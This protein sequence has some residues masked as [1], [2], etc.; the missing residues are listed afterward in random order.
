MEEKRRQ[1][2]CSKGH[3]MAL[4]VLML[5]CMISGSIIY[6]SSGQNL[7]A[8]AVRTQ[9]AEITV[10]EPSINDWTE[11]AQNNTKFI[12][13]IWTD[14]TVFKDDVTLP[15]NP[16]KVD[17]GESDFLIALSAISSTSNIRTLSG[18]V[19]LDIVMVLDTSGSM[20]DEMGYE[21]AETYDDGYRWQERYVLV[22][23][24]YVRIERRGII[25]WTWQLN[26][27]NIEVKHSASDSGYQMYERVNI[28]KMDSLK[29]AVNNFIDA[30]ADI[31]DGISES[32]E[33][34]RI[35]IVNY[36]SDSSIR[37]HFAE[38]TKDNSN[39][40]K[41]VV[42]ELN[43]NGA[44]AADYGMA[45]AAEEIENSRQ[46]AKTVVIFFT[47]G[48]PNHQNGFD[49]SVA[50]SAIGTAKVLKDGGTV[51]YSVGIFEN[52]DPEGS[53][54]ANRYMNGISNNYPKAESYTN[55]GNRVSEDANYYK[56]AS[57][58]DGLN[59]IFNEILEESVSNAGYPTHIERP[60]GEPVD[61]SKSGYVTFTDK[62]GA[63]MQ[64]DSFKS[65]VFADERFDLPADGKTTSGDTDTYVFEGT[66]GNTLY[67]NGNLSS[68][69]ITVKHGKNLNDG[70]LV[71]VSVPAAMIP[72]RDFDVDSENPYSVTTTVNDTWPIRIFYG[73][74]LKEGIVKALENPD[75]ALA[76]YISENSKDGKVSFYSNDFTKENELGNTTSE[77]TPAL[78]NSFYYFT[79]DSYLF[80]DEDCTVPITGNIQGQ[81]GYYYQRTYY[82]K[83]SSEPK[84]YAIDITGSGLNQLLEAARRDTSK[85]GQYYIP[86][87]TP[88]LTTVSDTYKAKA[89]NP[90]GTAGVVISPV[91][92][93]LTVSGAEDIVV[94]LGNNGCID[95]DLPGTLKISK[96][97][98]TADGFDGKQ[99]ENTE[100]EF[101]ID[102]GEATGTYDTEIVSKDGTKTS[103]TI[104]NGDTF[105]LKTGE[106]IYIYGVEAGVNYI[107]TEES[108][109]GFTAKSE[110]NSGTVISG[111]EKDIKFTNTYK[112]EI[113]ASVDTSEFFKGYK[114]LTGRDW[115]A[116][117]SFRFILD[118]GTAPEAEKPDVTLTSEEDGNYKENSRVEFDFGKVIFT[119]PGVYKYDIFEVEPTQTLPGMSYSSARYQV[120]VTVEDNGDGTMSAVSEMK[121]VRN[122]EGEQTEQTVS[123]AAFTNKY[124]AKSVMYGPIGYKE[125][126]DLSGGGMPLENCNFKFRVTPLTEGAPVPNGV[127][128]SEKSFTV[129]QGEHQINYGNAEFT[130]QHD[131]PYY[132]YLLEEV[133][134][135]G[136][137]ETNNYVLNGMR[138][139]PAKYIARFE[140][141]VVQEPGQ[142][143]QIKVTV[144]YWHTIDGKTPLRLIDDRAIHFYNSYDPEDAVL[145]GNTAL[146]GEKTIIGRDMKDEEMFTFN[147]KTDDKTTAQ[148]V[149]DGKIVI[150]GWD[151]TEEK[152][153][154]YVS[155]AKN[156]VAAGFNFGDA[157][158]TEV[159]TYKF[160]ITEESGNAGGVSYD[161]HETKV[162]VTVTDEKGVLKAS[163]NY[164][165][166][167]DRHDDKAVFENKYKASLDYGQ[168]GGIIVT[169][170][171][172]GRAMNSGEFVFTMTSDDNE[173]SQSDAIFT[174]PSGRDGDAVIMKKLQ[175]LKFTEADVGKTFTY[176]LDE[177]DA[178][179]AKG[180][181]YD[182]SKYK[183][184]I[185]VIDSE[186]DGKLSAETV[187]TKI[188]DSQGK[189]VNETVGRYDSAQ[190]EI[191]QIAF[192][193]SYHAE[194]FDFET[195][196]LFTK[197]LRGRNW[198]DSDEFK[199][200]IEAVTENAPMPDNKEVKISKP[201]KGESVKFGFGKITY[202]SAGVYEYRITEEA[203]NIPGITYSSNEAVLRVTVSDNGDGTFSAVPGIISGTFE[204]VYRSSIDYGAAG[205]LEI[206]KTLTGRSMEKDLFEFTV[207]G[208]DKE[209]R[210]KLKIDENGLKFTNENAA[211]GETVTVL[212]LGEYFDFGMSDIGKTYTYE[213][214][215]TDKGAAGYVYDKT[216]RTVEISIADNLDGNMRVV[217]KINGGKDTAEYTY[218]TGEAAS[219]KASVNF[220]NKYQAETTAETAASL[221]ADKK[222][223]GRPLNDGE[224][225]FEVV[226]K[227][228]TP[229]AVMT[230][231]NDA[232]GTINFNKKFEYTTDTLEKAVKDG[233]AV[234]SES[235]KGYQWT[236]GY[237][238][239]EDTT[240]FEDKGITAANTAYDFTVIVTDNGDGTLT[241]KV[242]YPEGESFKFANVYSTGE[243][244]TINLSGSKTLKAEDGLLPDDI[245]GKFTFTLTGKDNAPMPALNKTQN[246]KDG[247]I[248]FGNVTFSLD[249]LKGVKTAEDGSRTK[250]F[251]Y[252]VSES[253]T[254]PGITNDTEKEFTVTL[255]DDGKGH[256]TAA[257]GEGPIFKFV[258][259][260]I[261][262]KPVY[263]SITDDIEIKKILDGADLSE[264]EFEFE[265]L[266]N[267]KVIA[268][269]KNDDSG[270]VMF[271]NIKYT[272]PGTHHYVVREVNSGIKGIT[273]DKDS[274][275]ITTEVKDNGDGTLS[276]EH[277]IAGDIKLITFENKYEITQGASVEI[278]ASK[279]LKGAELTKGQ[280]EFELLDENGKVISTAENDENGLILF[281][282]IK[283]SEPGN[284]KYTV[285][286]VNDGQ[287]GILYDEKVYDVAVKVR[288]VD[289]VLKADIEA[290]EMIFTNAVEKSDPPVEDDTPKTGDGSGIMGW[291]ML[292]AAGFAGSISIARRRKA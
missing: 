88:R 179:D 259:S 68:I 70:D 39:A 91:W 280:F 258:N 165:N 175:S 288:D 5:V 289:S 22:D 167:K 37:Q 237:I 236:L 61:A 137:D 269:A 24:E 267:D 277:S 123:A 117:E 182:K 262:E 243:P 139:D 101:K 195:E 142:E 266:E 173:L 240:G 197:V 194:P 77:F 87:G 132:D 85:G 125:Y 64:V 163:V 98:E 155:K 211:D 275:K 122:D 25:N 191:P 214:A 109:S 238:V 192:V 55:L 145:T 228:S 41:S 130:V 54:N 283:Y 10:D 7:S 59:N 176:I 201:E 103:G 43:A 216:I 253:G 223:T 47:D 138:Y 23:G 110:N 99:F 207:K 18:G 72:L 264:Y 27:E 287:K 156:G 171:L 250:V 285:R 14:K 49:G 242:N 273:Y 33:R 215:E 118:N 160:A 187:V 208:L 286:E 222:L 260:Y 17:K 140:P 169:K 244:I 174:N 154:A 120:T 152:A 265:L 97:V 199:F 131:E 65:I 230:G 252:V 190:N 129:G 21:Y 2:R 11:I 119:K 12:G 284:Y 75:T 279:I 69:I 143:A 256:L 210:E 44:T 213:I 276:A 51:I 218:I 28:S 73:V 3:L 115:K 82:E 58:S 239:S 281:D 226:T 46:D 53:S 220:E 272:K 257:T 162:T 232:R 247:N 16:I 248:S 204:N 13:R 159:G 229:E 48:E 86:A 146:H 96:N 203:G 185:T 93:E 79:E 92:N 9:N 150:N 95:L 157:T 209:S 263:S 233:Y 245:T 29:K 67:P 158:F 62:L 170:T 112:A 271:S 35:S 81:G 151:N 15:G 126:D 80:S 32:G 164:D 219:Q 133:I 84:T 292:A 40:L 177:K 31:N 111:Q 153:S 234:K 66:T 202:G 94:Y 181:T 102:L 278:G 180:I 255:K 56:V 8:A 134:P 251:E 231:R 135:Q 200:N 78:G 57:D 136:A 104:Q 26:G 193:N 225:K 89:D 149:A 1:K 113:P 291:I 107:V 290:G 188:M 227:D 189:E 127:D 206:T 148:A 178:E 45:S 42:N 124:D 108:K 261:I 63:Y 186:K 212:S 282:E 241:S 268:T 254:M 100:F 172:N 76:E 246:D 6:A 34:H 183:I 144:T 60:S 36:A 235:E 198:L 147:L 184:E 74:S 71:T 224:F 20:D 19:P 205:G 114:I 221:K 106:Q 50:N 52:A 83:D 249:M 141:E 270:K 38:C 105:K 90:T 274:Y 168:A 166:G 30:T 116:G 161:N 128:D 121:Q 196:G 217:T 4:I